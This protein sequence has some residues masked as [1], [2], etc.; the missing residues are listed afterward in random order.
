LQSKGKKDVKSPKTENESN[1]DENYVHKTPKTQFTTKFKSTP[2]SIGKI[3]MT[4][5]VYFF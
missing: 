5:Y 4:K 1:D 2:S 3:S